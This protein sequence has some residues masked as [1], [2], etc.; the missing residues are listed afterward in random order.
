GYFVRRH[1]RRI[2]KVVDGISPASMERLQTYL[3]PGNIRE[4]RTVIEHA[5]LVSKSSVLEIDE[6]LLNDQLAV[7]RY[8]H[9]APLGAGGTG[10]PFARRGARTRP[11]PSRY[12]TR[13]PV[14][15][16]ARIRVRLP[17]SAGFR[18]RQGS[19]GRRARADAAV[20]AGAAAGHA[21]IHGA[22]TGVLREPH[23]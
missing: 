14:R 9:I 22:G 12:Q 11:G 18:H 3:W 15:D 10:G 23:R 5:V 20:G 19:A 13:Q 8:R 2:G 6:E 17:E 1:A 21:G 7:G 4:L 16:P